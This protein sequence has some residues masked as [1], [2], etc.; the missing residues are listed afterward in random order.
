MNTMINLIDEHAKFKYITNDLVNCSRSIPTVML[1]WL[2]LAHRVQE[3]VHS[4]MLYFKLIS[5]CSIRLKAGRGVR[6]EC[7]CRTMA[8]LIS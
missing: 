7:G 8:S 3:K 1:M 6:R 5:L 2:F 4:S